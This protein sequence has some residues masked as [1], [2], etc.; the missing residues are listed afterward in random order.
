MIRE[1][2]LL[3]REEDIPLLK[4]VEKIK[5]V[6]RSFADLLERRIIHEYQNGERWADLHPA[7]RAIA[8]VDR[9]LNPPAIL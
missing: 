1:F 7:V 5:H 2:D 4:R 9:E 3:V 6:D 8:W